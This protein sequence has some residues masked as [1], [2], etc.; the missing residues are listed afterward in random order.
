MRIL[1]IDP[2]NTQSGV[3]LWDGSVR[4]SAQLQNEDVLKILDNPPPYEYGRNILAIE[5]VACYGMAVGKEVFETCVWIGRFQ[6]R[7]VRLGGPV[8][9]VYRHQVKI[10]L[11]HTMKAKD[12]NIRQA[13]IDKHGPVGTKKAPG[14]LFGISGHLWAA[15]AVADYVSD[16]IK[17]A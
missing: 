1:S 9:L 6:E 3:V 13:L 15:L 4:F 17:E 14:K 11:C 16:T 10:H 12:P 5:M 2:G 8:Q 7:S